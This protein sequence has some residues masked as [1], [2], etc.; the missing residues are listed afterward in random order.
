M[1]YQTPGLRPPFAHTLSLICYV[2]CNGTRL[3][4]F[5]GPCIQCVPSLVVLYRT[6][7]DLN[8]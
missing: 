6:T 7:V 1:I 2:R 4:L 8:N 5:S 3:T